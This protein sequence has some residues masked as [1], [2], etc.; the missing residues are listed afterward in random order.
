[1]S[2]GLAPDPPKAAQ[3]VQGSAWYVDPAV[4]VLDP[5]DRHLEDPVAEAFGEQ[6]ELS[7]EEPRL[8][9]HEREQTLSRAPGHRL[10]AA[11]SIR[12]SGWKGE[13]DQD[14]V[15]AGKDLPAGLAPDPRAREEP[16]PDRQ[17]AVAAK[18]RRQEGQEAPQVGGEVDVHVA[19]NLGLT[20]QPRRAQG[21][22]STFLLEVKGC[23]PRKRH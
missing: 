18:Q 19:D 5:V 3:V 20:R 8:I 23:H 7:V 13:G 2:P 15:A 6:Q 9:P 17:L 11:L 4:E 21:T 1:M 10:E 14:V 22:T 12:E 16:G